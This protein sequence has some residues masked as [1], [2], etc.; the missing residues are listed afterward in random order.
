MQYVYKNDLTKVYEESSVFVDPETG[1]QYGADWRTAS[2]VGM[3]GI[4]ESSQPDTGANVITGHHLAIVDDLP[5]V[6][7]DYRPKTQAELD[8]DFNNGVHGQI[9]ALERQVTPRRMREAFLRQA[10]NDWI[11]AKDAEIAALRALLK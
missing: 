9:A 1:T 8:Q 5:T 10:G 4:I 7:W 6:I 11:G 3:Q 2:I